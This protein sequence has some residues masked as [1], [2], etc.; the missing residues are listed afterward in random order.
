MLR[1]GGLQ[2]AW[3]SGEEHSTRRHDKWILGVE[4]GAHAGG[5]DAVADGDVGGACLA[6]VGYG[7]RME[8]GRMQVH[9]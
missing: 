6:R 9:G 3:H 8:E 2:V 5:F 1:V 7:W 4:M